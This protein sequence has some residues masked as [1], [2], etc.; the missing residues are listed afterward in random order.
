MGG[1]NGLR[2]AAAAAPP[3]G[4]TG[5][6]QG[7]SRQGGSAGAGDRAQGGRAAARAAVRAQATGRA[8]V[9]LPGRALHKRHVA[10]REEGHRQRVQPERVVGLAASWRSGEAGRVGAGSQGSSS[11]QRAQSCLPDGARLVRGYAHALHDTLQQHHVQRLRG[12]VRAADLWRS[13]LI[14]LPPLPPPSQKHRNFSVPSSEIKQPQTSWSVIMLWDVAD[15]CT[16]INERG[17][18]TEFPGSRAG[19]GCDDVVPQA[20]SATGAAKAPPH[21]HPHPHPHLLNGV[22]RVSKHRMPAVQ[23]RQYRRPVARGGRQ[24]A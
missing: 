21:P 20:F 5:Q 19:G 16:G 3:R 8:A 4:A 12:A 10:T 13:P 24:R 9:S 17:V 15:H 7:S 1:K 2:I 6:A 14:C 18:K 11:L 22:H 23:R